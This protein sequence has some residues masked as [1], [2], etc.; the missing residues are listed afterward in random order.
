MRLH[1][2]NVTSVR[3][4]GLIHFGFYWHKAIDLNVYY[5]SRNVLSAQNVYSMCV[6]V[7]LCV[8]HN[9]SFNHLLFTILGIDSLA[10][11]VYQSDTGGVHKQHPYDIC[12]V[13]KLFTLRFLSWFFCHIHYVHIRFNLFLVFFCHSPRLYFTSIL[14]FLLPNESTLIKSR[15]QIKQITINNFYTSDVYSLNELKRKISMNLNGWRPADSA[16]KSNFRRKTQI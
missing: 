15:H 8:S 14:F 11:T 3:Y 7:C 10:H 2:I 4:F 6:C 13:N 9:S 16:C 1:K 12:F 5:L